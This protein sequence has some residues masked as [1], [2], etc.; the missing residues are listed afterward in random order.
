MARQITQISIAA[1]Q[2][3]AATAEIDYHVRQISDAIGSTSREAGAVAASA[4]Q[5]SALTVELRGL[6]AR[7]SV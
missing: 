3:T 4:G 5:L 2:Q 6:V 7:F 1:E